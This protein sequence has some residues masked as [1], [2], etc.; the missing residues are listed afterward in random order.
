MW[1][2]VG[3]FGSEQLLSAVARQILHDVGVFAPAVVT[4]ARIT[5][6]IFVGKHRARGFKHGFADE[7]FRGN[8]LQPLMLAA[9][10][11]VDG[12]RNLRIGFVKRAVHLRRTLHVFS[13]G[14]W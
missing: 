1:L 11:I 10:F 9:G 2:H 4:L 12:C 5:L 6:G 8:Q 7:I 13:W 3:M 14:A